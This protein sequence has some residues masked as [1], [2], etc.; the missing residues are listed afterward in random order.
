MSSSQQLGTAATGFLASAGLFLWGVGFME[1]GDKTQK[2]KY[3]ASEH[4]M[5][6][7][8]GLG[9]MAGALAIFTHVTLPNLQM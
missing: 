7:G 1:E 4:Y 8:L 6:Y 3:S 2:Q 9:A 5:F